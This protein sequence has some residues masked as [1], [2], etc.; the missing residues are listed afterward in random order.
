[1]TRQLPPPD[2]WDESDLTTFLQSC[3]LNTLKWFHDDKRMWGLIEGVDR[4]WDKWTPMCTP[5][6]RHGAAV[7]RVMCR[8]AFRGALRLA[9]AGQGIESMV[10]ARSMLEQALYSYKAETDPEAHAA[11]TDRMDSA[12]ARDV[13]RSVFQWGKVR[14]ALEAAA[15]DLAAEADGLYRLCIDYG[16]HPNSRAA[17]A[18]MQALPPDGLLPG[19]LEIELLDASGRTTMFAVS[20]IMRCAILSHRVFGLAYPEHYRSCGISETVYE[21][22]RLLRRRVGDTPEGDLQRQSLESH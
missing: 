15:P 1:M 14:R 22:V 4:L 3:H 20:Q 18:R 12:R 16:G 21:F 8:G 6:T 5:V 11:W 2:G 10:L 7:L 9:L 19:R 13:S 17:Y